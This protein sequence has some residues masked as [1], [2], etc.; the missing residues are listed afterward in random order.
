[1]P[2]TKICDFRLI[3][4][5]HITYADMGWF[6]MTSKLICRLTDN[7]A[8]FFEFRDGGFVL[9]CFK[10]WQVG[11]PHVTGGRVLKSPRNCYG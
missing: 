7:A 3:L 2:K 5:H 10:Q 1:M 9:F 8:L 11:H 4:L 6:G